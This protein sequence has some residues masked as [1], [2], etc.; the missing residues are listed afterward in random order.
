MLALYVILALVLIAEGFEPCWV[1]FLL[2][3][4]GFDILL[5]FVSFWFIAFV[6][7]CHV[8]PFVTL[9]GDHR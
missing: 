4:N 6:S 7:L 1:C 3:F 5:V 8:L 9:L 2:V